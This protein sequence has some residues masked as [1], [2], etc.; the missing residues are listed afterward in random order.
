VTAGR[1]RVPDLRVPTLESARLRLEPLSEAHSEDMYD[2]WSQAQVCEHSG[3]ATD[4][5]GLAIPLPAASRSESDRLLHFWLDRARAGT[6]FRW[7]VML[8]EED[9]FAGAVGFNALGPSSE[10]AYH[11]VPRFWK[12]GLAAEASRLAVAWAFGR[13]AESIESFIERENVASIRL[14][15]RL[16]FRPDEAATSEVPRYL[17][18]KEEHTAAPASG[19]AAR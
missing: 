10:Y 5:A 2:L 16:G 17:L 6:G 12:R 15:E 7:A 3:P 14:A 11:F 19:A 18:T 13:G 1:C 8:R 4:S 9:A